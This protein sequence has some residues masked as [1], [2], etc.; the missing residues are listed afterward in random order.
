LSLS[1]RNKIVLT[2]SRIINEKRN[3]LAEKGIINLIESISKISPQYPDLRLL[4]AVAKPPKSLSKE[5]DIALEMLKGYI[6]LRNIADQTILKIF[7][8]SEMPE[9][10][11]ESD[12]FVL[13]SENETFGQ[14][15]IESMACGLPVIGTKVG[16]IPEII[17]DSYNGYLVPPDDASI[18]AQRIETVL[19]NHAIRKSF[20][21]AGKKTVQ[22]KFTL[23]KQFGK[24]IEILKTMA[25]KR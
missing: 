18:L 5:F 12:L 23:E 14:V 3:I 25:G 19:N 4:I 21:K 17:T 7:N 16:G 15:F 22:D 6:Q 24:F 20:I 2:A 8:L 9:V 11:R 1:N 13:P 10:Y